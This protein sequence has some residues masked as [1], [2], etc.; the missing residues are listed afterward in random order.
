MHLYLSA[1]LVSHLHP[2]DLAC[3]AACARSTGAIQELIAQADS[4]S[5]TCAV[6]PLPVER[7]GTPGMRARVV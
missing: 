1:P 7:V 6:Q 4:S 2:W 3:S 5:V